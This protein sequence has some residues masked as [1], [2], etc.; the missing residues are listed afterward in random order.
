MKKDENLQKAFSEYT[1]G[2]KAP[3]IS[4]ENAKNAI[5]ERKSKGKLTRRI[6]SF[7]SVFACAVIIFAGMLIYRN[8]NKIT[9]YDSASLK[10]EVTFYSELKDGDL[11]V[12]VSPLEKM[13]YAENA[14]LDYY[15]YYDGETVKFIKLEITKLNDYGRED[16]TV[17]IELTGKKS[18]CKDFEEYYKLEDKNTLNGNK[19][20]FKKEQVAGEW[21]SSAYMAT[22]DAKYFIDV[23]SPYSGSL[24]KYL[25][26]FS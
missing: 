8:N 2:V 24:E 19:Y 3:D 13:E 20:K 25:K 4:L 21:V 12:Y 15:L 18:T 14:H 7:A 11:S 23:E 10:Q 22:S 1:G 17:F 6:V 26:I 9:Y 16:V 5:R